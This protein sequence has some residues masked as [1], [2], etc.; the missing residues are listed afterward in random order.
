MLIFV[1][2]QGCAAKVKP[3][4]RGVLSKPEMAWAPNAMEAQLE[5]HIFFSKEAST[6]GGEAVGGGCGCN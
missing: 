6:G 1:C 4:E 2:I 5:S 3:W